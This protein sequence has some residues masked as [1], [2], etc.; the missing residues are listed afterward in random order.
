MVGLDTSLYDDQF[1]GKNPPY[2][3]PGINTFS[4]Y[5][6][7]FIRYVGKGRALTLEEA[8]QKTATMPA[9]VHNL[10]DR[11]V[12]QEGSYADIVLMNMPNLEILGDELEPRRY[13][14][15]VEYVFVNGRAVVEKGSH[16][17]EKPG[18]VLTRND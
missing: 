15:G 13:R 5:P 7:F 10:Q 17:G 14:K 8:V 6:L 9:R 11:G 12:I 4:A 3:I 1:Q 2:T 16:T 18:R